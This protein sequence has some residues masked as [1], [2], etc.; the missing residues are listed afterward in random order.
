MGLLQP[1]L[2]KWTWS[3][4][5]KFPHRLILNGWSKAWMIWRVSWVLKFREEHRPYIILLEIFQ[6]THCSSWNQISLSVKLFRWQNHLAVNTSP[7][8]SRSES[9][10]S[11]YLAR[12]ALH[13]W[14][15]LSLE[16]GTMVEPCNPNHGEN[17]AYR[18]SA[19]AYRA[20]KGQSY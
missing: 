5:P 17:R 3:W 7:L 8:I 16:R 9:G 20:R 12:V 15:A 6:Q 19:F 14:L 1:K 2:N 13:R 4:S 18:G 10:R 11:I